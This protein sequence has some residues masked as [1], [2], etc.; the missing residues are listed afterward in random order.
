VSH[1]YILFFS[2]PHS[3]FKY[4]VDA[5]LL[6]IF[7]TPLVIGHGLCPLIGHLNTLS[8]ERRKAAVDGSERVRQG[9]SMAL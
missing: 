6:A 9:A 1:L 3:L 5:P 7:T 8:M 4:Y 2:S